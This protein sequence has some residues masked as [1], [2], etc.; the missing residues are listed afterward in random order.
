MLRSGWDCGPSDLVG[1]I[2]GW[3]RLLLSELSN[4]R[5]KAELQVRSDREAAAGR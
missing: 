2:S 4:M 5:S 1:Q 3:L